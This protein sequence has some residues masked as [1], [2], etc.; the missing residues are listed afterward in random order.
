MTKPEKKL[1]ENEGTLHLYD[2]IISTVWASIW[3]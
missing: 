2:K 3:N 1:F